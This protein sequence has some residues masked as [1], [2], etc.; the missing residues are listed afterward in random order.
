MLAAMQ[1]LS[2]LKIIFF[3]NTH[4]VKYLVIIAA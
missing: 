1:G 2:D 4:W 3:L